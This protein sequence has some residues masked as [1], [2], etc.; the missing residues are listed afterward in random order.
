MEYIGR[1]LTDVNVLIRNWWAVLLRGALG[2]L[3]GIGTF[4]W[5]GLSFA[6]LV[7][8]FAGYAFVDGV[9]SLVSAL[10]GRTGRDPRWLAVLRGLSGLAAGIL[11]LVWPG[12]T[13][14]A[15][16]YLVAA[17]ALV[18][19]VLEIVAAV[20]LRKAITGEWLLA[21]S[22]VLS[23]ALG[24]MLIL[25]PAAGAI[26]LV[27]WLGAYALVSGVILL[28]LGL[29]LRSWGKHG[30]PPELTEPLSAGPVPASH[31]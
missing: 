31:P 20:R 21:I 24:I 29:R 5:P 3:F 18:G 15:L 6:A 2:I 25:F 14:F 16:L 4:L 30:L 8:V 13:A 19:G 10:R 9:F 23:I 12:I 27:L 22:G 26:G 28:V 1:S 7:L 11:T 17:W